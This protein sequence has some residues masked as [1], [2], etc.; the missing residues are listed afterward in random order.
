M[1]PH[2]AEKHLVIQNEFDIVTARQL[3]RDY[4]RSI[5]LG[6]A[7]QAKLTAAISAVSRS[8]YLADSSVYVTFK[9]MNEHPRVGLSVIYESQATPANEKE[10]NELLQMD[11]VQKLV[12]AASIT[13]SGQ[14]ATLTL[15]MWM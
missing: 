5:G 12:D 10:L 4:A 1:R 3:C 15:S 8:F 2:T 9:V 11:A 14:R 13:T 7:Q 6:L